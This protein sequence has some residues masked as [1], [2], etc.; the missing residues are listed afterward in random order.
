MKSS[1]TDQKIKNKHI[2]MMKTTELELEKES[3]GGKMRKASLQKM[4]LK[5]DYRFSSVNS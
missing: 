1:A 3:L 4:N 2:A 5:P